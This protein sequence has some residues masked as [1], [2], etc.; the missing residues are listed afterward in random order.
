MN[1]PPPEI[2]KELLE[3]VDR[4]RPFA[5]A[6]VE[7]LWQMEDAGISLEDMFGLMLST[8]AAVLGRMPEAEIQEQFE[9]LGKRFGALVG[10]YQ[11]LHEHVRAGEVAETLISAMKSGAKKP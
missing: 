2:P 1:E 8:S 6:L 9:T 10:L 4:Q 5:A 3:R 11:T 7:L